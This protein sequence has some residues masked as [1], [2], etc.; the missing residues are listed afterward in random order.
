MLMITREEEAPGAEIS[1]K[2]SFDGC[3]GKR[4]VLLKQIN[5]DS[6]NEELL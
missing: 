2:S 4:L 5:I 6:E 3:R 1:K